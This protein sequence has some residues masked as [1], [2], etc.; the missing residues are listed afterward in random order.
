VWLAIPGET[1]AL[2]AAAFNSGMSKSVVCEDSVVAPLGRPTVK[3]V[4]GLTLFNHGAL[5]KRKWPVQPDFTIDVSC[6]LRSGGVRQT[7]NVGFLFKVAA[8][9]HHSL[10]AWLPPMF[11]A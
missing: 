1:C 7:S 6:C 10:L 2:D 3:E 11:T 8:L 5:T 4:R 9:E